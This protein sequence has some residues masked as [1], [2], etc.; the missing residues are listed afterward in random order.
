MDEVRNRRIFT[1]YHDCTKIHKSISQQFE[2]TK[3]IPDAWKETFAKLRA[4]E[5]DQTSGEST[6]NLGTGLL[7]DDEGS[8][9]QILILIT[10][11]LELVYLNVNSYLVSRD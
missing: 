11:C 4:L 7:L 10:F 6:L 2:H 9:T 1:F 8:T 5:M 3:Y